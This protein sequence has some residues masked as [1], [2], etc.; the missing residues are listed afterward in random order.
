MTATPYRAAARRFGLIGHPVRHSVSPAM[1]RAAF[2]ALGLPFTYDAID[3]PDGDALARCAAAL[4][5]GE[6]AGFNVTIPHKQAAVALADEVGESAAQVGAA[7][8]LAVAHHGR[9]RAENTDADAIVRVLDPLLAARRWAL[10]I[11]S[12][13]AARAALCACEALGFRGVEITS[14]SWTTWEKAWELG[15]DLPAIEAE[16]ALVPWMSEWGTPS[17]PEREADLVVQ[18]TSA[19]MAGA[20]AGDAVAE[21]VPWDA[22]PPRAVAFDVVYR[23]RRTPFL[24][25][26]RGHGLV[27]LDGVAMLVEQ[28]ALSLS[29]WLGVDPPRDVMARAAEEALGAP[30]RAQRTQ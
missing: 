7:N 26:A 15:A 4:R 21:R 23:P 11:G 28:A 10:I 22:L 5:A 16:V 27:A 2:D 17:V 18:A 1:M 6:R 20:D 29:L 30:D 9:I 8:V 3:A 12:G 24:D 25:A 13:G 14:R 19:G